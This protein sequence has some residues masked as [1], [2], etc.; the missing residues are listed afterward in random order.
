MWTCAEY[1]QCC[2]K[3]QVIQKSEFPEKMESCPFLILLYIGGHLCYLLKHT[4]SIKKHPFQSAHPPPHLLCCLE[5][6]SHPEI[7]TQGKKFNLACT[8]HTLRKV[9]IFWSPTSSEYYPLP[10]WPQP[11]SHKD[12]LKK[13]GSSSQTPEDLQC[14]SSN[15]IEIL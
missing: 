6:A 1:G 14:D 7:L 9:D 5:M 10:M 3:S 11:L 8:P 4:L 12:H 2:L 13:T 15:C